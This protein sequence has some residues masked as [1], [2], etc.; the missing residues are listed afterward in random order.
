MWPQAGPVCDCTDETVQNTSENVQSQVRGGS[1][2]ETST[3]LKKVE[4]V[5]SDA[6]TT[7]FCHPE[8]TCLGEYPLIFPLKGGKNKKHMVNEL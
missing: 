6:K 8:N 5:R 3:D 4:D 2:W 1:T 7:F